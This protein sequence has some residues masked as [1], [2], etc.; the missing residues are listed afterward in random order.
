MATP[1]EQLGGS[2][3]HQVSDGFDAPEPRLGQAHRVRIRSL[4]AMQKEALVTGSQSGQTWRL[5]SDEGPYLDGA[6]IGPPPLAFLATGMV[7]SYTDELL[8]AADRRGVALDDVEVVLDNY[9]AIN[10]S[11]LQGTMEGSAFAPDLAVTVETDAD[12]SAV[13]NAVDAA[14]AGA[15]VTGF[16]TDALDSRFRLGLNGSQIEPEGVH[17][18]DGDLRPDPAAVFETLDRSGDAERALIR[19]TGRTTDPYEAADDKYTGSDAAGYAD[20]QDR[21]IHLRATCSVLDDGLKRIEQEL[22]SPRGSVFEFHSDEPAGEGGEGRAPDAM[23]Y[24]A[25]GVGFC[26]MTQLGRYAHA[27]DTELTGY[28]L[29]QDTHV[30]TSRARAGS[31]Q[32]PEATPVETDLFIDTPAD[33]EF[34]RTALDM[35]EQTCYLH[36]LCRTPGLEPTVDL[37]VA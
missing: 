36:A 21:K 35:S 32:P 20:E 19:H 10:G 5:A 16:L 31:D 29:V 23:G 8:A 18:L 4:T 37:T 33:A 14:V 30:S 17:A 34:A 27:M 1:L 15:P 11:L 13:E 26:F 9:Y 24:V 12:R 28:R 2:L 7:S 3:C 6:D 25:A 22:F